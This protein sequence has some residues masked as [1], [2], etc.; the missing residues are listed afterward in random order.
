MPRPAMERWACPAADSTAVRGL[1]ELNSGAHRGEFANHP[2][3]IAAQRLRFRRQTGRGFCSMVFL[4]VPLQ[5]GKPAID[6]LMP[7][8]IAAACLPQRQFEVVFYR[9]AKMDDGRY[10]KQRLDAG[11]A[12]SV[13]KLTWET[14]CSSAHDRANRRSKRRRCR[15][16]LNGRS[17]KGPVWTQPGMADFSLA[18]AGLWT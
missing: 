12:R 2:Y 1:T 11:V 7:F 10:A 6:Q 8:Q 13:T 18:C 4:R 17:V 9:D 14:R 5:T 15:I 16:T 3:D